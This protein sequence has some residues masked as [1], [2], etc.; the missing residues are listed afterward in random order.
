MSL[1]NA[2]IKIDSNSKGHRLDFM[3]IIDFHGY[4]KFEIIFGF[5][6]S[7]SKVNLQLVNVDLVDLEILIKDLLDDIYNKRVELKIVIFEI[8]SF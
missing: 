5:F 6:K 8:H 7:P 2:S 1:A 3:F 4:N